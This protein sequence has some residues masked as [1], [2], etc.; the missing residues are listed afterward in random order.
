M[1]LKPQNEILLRDMKTKNTK[2]AE[3]RF[4]DVTG[5][6]LDRNVISS[7]NA[8]LTKHHKIS[9]NLSTCT[10]HDRFRLLNHFLNGMAGICKPRDANLRGAHDASS[11]WSKPLTVLNKQ[12]V[13][14][15]VQF[16]YDF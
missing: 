2:Y 7:D 9:F 14:C 15:N 10:Q 11:N 4:F 8:F 5:R 1:K 6:A 12:I 13:R 3:N 16:S